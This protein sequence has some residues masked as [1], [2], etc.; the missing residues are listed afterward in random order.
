MERKSTNSGWQTISEQPPLYTFFWRPFITPVTGWAVLSRSAILRLARLG[1]F[2]RRPSAAFHRAWGGPPEIPVTNRR[3]PSRTPRNGPTYA[4]APIW[5]PTL[6]SSGVM[7]VLQYAP[8]SAAEPFQIPIQTLSPTPLR[9]FLIAYS[10]FLF[11]I[12][13]R[14]L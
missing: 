11:P 10:A 3:T 14:P 13:M 12:V 2:P 1:C 5:S 8:E 4:P 9:S 6:N 7:S